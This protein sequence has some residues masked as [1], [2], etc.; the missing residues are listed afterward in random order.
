VDKD[1]VWHIGEDLAVAHLAALGWRVLERNWR[2]AA[3]ELDI[4]AIEPGASAVLVFCEVKCRRNTAYGQ[5]IE[6][7]TEAKLAKLR[8]LALYWL[9]EQRRPIPSLRF[10]GIGVL[11]RAGS[12][13]EIDHRRG[14]C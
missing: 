1:E 3:G 7:I 13:P 4:I 11:L 2:C 6:A 12:K 14:I 8:Q 9:Q 10:D 5:P